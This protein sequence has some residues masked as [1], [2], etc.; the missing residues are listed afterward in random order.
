MTQQCESNTKNLDT[1]DHTT[2]HSKSSAATPTRNQNTDAV[3]QKI[4]QHACTRATED[5][6]STGT[7]LKTQTCT[8]KTKKRRPL[9]KKKV[10]LKLQHNSLPLNRKHLPS[11]TTLLRRPFLHVAPPRHRSS[12]TDQKHKPAHCP[13]NMQPPHPMMCHWTSA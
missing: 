10:D 7:H 1:P 13:K 3:L 4:Y 2:K 12:G 5:S 8:L 9:L 6:Q 11:M